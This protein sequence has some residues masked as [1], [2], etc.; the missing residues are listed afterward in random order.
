MDGTCDV[1]HTRPAITKMTRSK[2]TLQLTH[3]ISKLVELE[4]PSIE[5]LHLHHM[6]DLTVQDAIFDKAGNKVLT[7]KV[8]MQ[9][10]PDK[11]IYIQPKMVIELDPE[12]VSLNKKNQRLPSYVTSIDVGIGERPSKRRRNR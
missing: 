2:K 4:I 1:N 8:I 7:F 9:L 11:T 10:N 6:A 12:F 3:N 5:L